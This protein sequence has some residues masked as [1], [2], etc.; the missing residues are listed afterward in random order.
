[1]LDVVLSIE[2]DLFWKKYQSEST[3]V[4]IKGYIYNVSIRDVVEHVSKL[5]VGGV[6][7]YI[8]SLDGHFSIV[9]KTSEYS[10]AAVDKIRSTPLYYMMIDGVYYVS[11][12]PTNLILDPGFK[13]S[14]IEDSLL[15]IIMSG[16]T[17]GNKTIFQGLYSLVAG[18]LVI[19]SKDLKRVKYF[20][21]CGEIGSYDYSYYVQSL[22]SLTIKIFKKMVS[23]IGNRQIVVPL[24][25]GNDSRLVASILKYLN[26]KNVKCYSYGLKG[27]FDVKVAQ[28]VA[29]KLGYEWLLVPLNSKTEKKYY[30]SQDYKRYLKF[31]ETFCSIPYVQGLSSILYLKN[32]GWI[33]DDAIFI[34]GNSG[35]FISGGHISSLVNP[36]IRSN[37]TEQK[38]Q[39]ILNKSI[40]K[41]FS[42][43]GYLKTRSNIEIIK[44]NLWNDIPPVCFDDIFS[45]NKYSQLYECSEFINRQSKYVVSGQRAYEFYGHEWRLPLWDN[46]YIEF[47]KKIPC[48]LKKNQ[49]IYID[50]LYKTNFGDV[51]RG[52]IPV[53]KINITPFYI[54]PIRFLFKVVFGVFGKS[55]WKRIDRV[56]FNY[57]MINN[58]NLKAFDYL[59]IIKDFHKDPRGIYPSF[60]SYDYIKKTNPASPLLEINVLKK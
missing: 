53:N 59:R 18:E 41:H 56:V 9:A 3:T 58:Q 11:N 45:E 17:I 25:A 20:N 46:E 43:W 24:S 29:K 40:E 31:A 21:Y 7:E 14:H 60:S 47:W 23:Q 6:E 51:W 27:N 10:F 49:N 5:N 52:G 38:K 26:V 13:K 57:W 54:I 36:L 2:E 28:K 39:T 35:D 48:Q 16:Y 15:E 30:V 32:I 19:F 8:N 37:T 42:L 1:M 50:M 22:S 34:N 44:N 4:Y 55:F 33:D 12:N